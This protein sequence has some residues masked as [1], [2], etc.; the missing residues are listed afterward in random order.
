MKKKKQIAIILLL[1]L[2]NIALYFLGYRIPR[3]SFYLSFC[4]YTFLFAAH[5]AIYKLFD[6]KWLN[7]KNVLLISLLSRIVLIGAV[8]QLSDDYNRFIWDG[9]LITNQIDPYKYT[10]SEILDILPREG[11]PFFKSLYESLNSP[12]YYSI[13]P[14]T[15]QAVFAAAATIG[16]D[17]VYWNVIVIRV[18]LVALEMLTIVFLFL[19]SE[20]LRLPPGKIL[21]YALNPLVLI[22][23]TG[24]LHFEGMML[25]FLLIALYCIAKDK[26]LLS[27]AFFGLSIA[28][29]I[30]P[31]V[32]FPA[33]CAYLKKP[34]TLRFASIAGLVVALFF[35]PIVLYGSMG[36][37]LQSIRLYHGVFEFN[38]SAYY[39]LRHIGI[40]LFQNNPVRVLGPVLSVL[41]VIIIFGRFWKFKDPSIHKLIEGIVF[42]YFI[43]YLLNTVVHPWYLLVGL[44][45]SILTN[46]KYFIAWSCLIFLSYFTYRTSAYTESTLLLFVE[47][48]GLLAVVLYDYR[49]YIKKLR[50]NSLR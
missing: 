18:V 17:S 27:G 7:L 29:K 44:G 42:S 20:K 34:R 45:I 38:A 25:L 13:Y 36:Q 41:T 47:Y 33:F 31:V 10:P 32:L 14:I 19:L 23:I 5:L 30:T 4:L 11:L 40:L 46:K 9:H 24:N 22:E 49:S 2:F 8:P 28:V 21:L 43:F 12:D 1:L 26:N 16:S 6:E 50:F 35:L 3:A 37:F 15:N 39:V 48:L